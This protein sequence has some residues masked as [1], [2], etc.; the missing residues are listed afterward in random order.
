ML[1]VNLSS[2]EQVTALGDNQTL[3]YNPATFGLTISDGNSVDLSGL[4]GGG[5]GGGGS[6][7]GLAITAS[8]EGVLLS[9][10]IRSMNFVGDSVIATSDGNAL[11]LTVSTGSTIRTLNVTASM[12]LLD[13]I[14]GNEPT[15]KAGG[16]MYSGS[17]FY[18]GL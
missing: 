18:V 8:D 10:N 15:A 11:T 5:G 4:S 16:I 2:S 6:G 14:I 9:P 17:G 1:K 7:D 3:A 13:P 12:F